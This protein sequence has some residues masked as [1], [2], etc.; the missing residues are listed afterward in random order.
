MKKGINDTYAQ[1]SLEEFCNIL[2]ML[3]S[4][5]IECNILAKELLRPFVY[6]INGNKICLTKDFSFE[7]KY[8]GCFK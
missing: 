4:K 7:H 8:N 3:K 2:E 5:D 6:E 1:M